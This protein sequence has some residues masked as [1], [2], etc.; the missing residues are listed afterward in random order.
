MEDAVSIIG[1]FRRPGTWM[2]GC[3]LHVI[4]GKAQIAEP[5]G[6]ISFGRPEPGRAPYVQSIRQ[7]AP[8]SP[9]GD[10]AY[11]YKLAHVRSLGPRVPGDTAC[12]ARRDLRGLVHLDH[13]WH[14][15]SL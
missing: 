6:Y 9:G 13:H 11:H 15:P 3:S 2:L 10:M 12:S 4:Q 14:C 5:A 1:S 8:R 7:R